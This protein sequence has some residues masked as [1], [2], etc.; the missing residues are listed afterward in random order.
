[1]RSVLIP[2]LLTS[3]VLF[4][5]GQK[6]GDD[7]TTVLTPPATADMPADETH[8]G[9]TGQMTGGGQH[10]MGLNTEI[11]MADEVST[12]WRGAV[13]QVAGPEGE[14]Q[15]YDLP[16]GEAV[17]LGDSGLTATALVFVPDFVMG[18]DGITT[19]S[20]EAV[21]PALRL[22]VTEEGRPD[23]EG[24]LFAAIPGIHP[25][26]HDTYSILL[27]DGLPAE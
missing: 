6:S 16:F 1:M 8:S 3:L 4:G 13:I 2:T 11:T 22:R 19:R 20:A 9:M 26:P 5:C 23:Y 24:W 10:D 18:E 15:H 25:F 7:T 14:P 21:N 12:A 27:A 17:A